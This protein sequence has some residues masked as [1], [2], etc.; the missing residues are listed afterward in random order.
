MRSAATKANTEISHRQT[1]YGRMPPVTN[2]YKELLPLKF[3][4]QR[5]AVLHTSCLR[6][7]LS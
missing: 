3:R 5:P 6:P 1:A 2:V 4:W 7:P